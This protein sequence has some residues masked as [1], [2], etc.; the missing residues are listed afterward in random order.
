MSEIRMMQ[1]WYLSLYEI[2]RSHR[3]RYLQEGFGLEHL[4]DESLSLSRMRQFFSE[5][6]CHIIRQ[7]ARKE[8]IPHLASKLK[9][10]DIRFVFYHTTGYPKRLLNIPDPPCGLFY[11]GS[12]PADDLFYVG[13]V[14]A[15][16]CTEYGRRISQELGKRLSESGIGVISGMAA[17]IDAAS[18]AG[19]L[20]ADGITYAVMG[21]GCDV[22]Y[23][24]SSRNLFLRI[25]EDG[26]ILSEYLPGTKPLPYLF[27]E[28]N[29]LISGLSDVVVVV[30]ARD[31]SGSL[32]TADCALDQGRDIYAV[33]GRV[34]DKTSSGCNRLIDQGAY[35]LHDIGRFI[36]DV[37]TKACEKCI[38]VAAEQTTQSNRFPNPPLEKEEQLVYS[39]LDLHP[40]N[41]FILLEETGLSLERLLGALSVLTKHG[42]AEEAQRNAYVRTTVMPFRM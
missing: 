10:A 22:C 16:M 9:Q 34:G 21:C 38:R 36:E 14:G 33:P 24:S 19:A 20:Q 28:R 41:V 26:G 4:Y 15:R 1:L 5:E 39:C 40:K 7:T 3:I 37:R 12:L 2:S 13:I 31:K 30:E 25:P 23:P 35:M 27:P 6:E 29:R 42:L 11:R 32:I 8:M 17:G 18:H